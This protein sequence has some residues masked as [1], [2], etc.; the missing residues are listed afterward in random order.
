VAQCGGEL[1]IVSRPGS[2]TQ[3]K[4]RIPLMEESLRD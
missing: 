4:V 2:G 3:V 1:E